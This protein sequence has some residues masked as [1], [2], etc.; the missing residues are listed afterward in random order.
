VCPKLQ[1]KVH[2]TL[3]KIKFWYHKQEE[4]EGHKTTFLNKVDTIFR[5]PGDYGFDSSLPAQAAS[6]VHD[7]CLFKVHVPH[8]AV[9]FNEVK[10]D[11]NFAIDQTCGAPG[12]GEEFVI[13]MPIE[14]AACHSSNL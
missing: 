6:M 11:S 5:M 3:W 14:S 12:C 10:E 7:L 2:S 1:T 9:A 13:S 8:H 4:A